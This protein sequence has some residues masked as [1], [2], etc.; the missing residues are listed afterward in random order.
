MTSVYR[1]Y[2]EI[3]CLSV[4]NL[5]YRTK[6]ISY[7]RVSVHRTRS[8]TSPTHP[9][10]YMHTPTHTARHIHNTPA[11][12]YRSLYHS[13]PPCPQ[14][15][16][17]RAHIHR[18]LTVRPLSVAPPNSLLQSRPPP[19]DPSERTLSREDRVHLSRLRCGHHTSLPHYMHRIGRAPTDT[20]S[21][22]HAA[23]GTVEHVLLHCPTIQTHRDARN[24]H[25]LEHLW[26]RPAECLLCLKDAGVVQRPN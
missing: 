21:L 11:E 24:I 1:T 5:D 25:S 2:L 7:L 23:V 6:F 8:T 17:E 19:V 13:L 3:S 14:G 20:C 4:F 10:H 9:L 15:L 26:T 18:E 22:C 16:S 12:H